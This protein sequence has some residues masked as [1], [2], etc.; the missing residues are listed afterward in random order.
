MKTLDL[1]ADIYNILGFR[2]GLDA[3]AHAT[4]GSNKSADGLMAIQWF[5]EGKLEQLI[6]YCC[7]DVS[8]TKKLYESG[9]DNGFVMYNDRSGRKKKIDVAWR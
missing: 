2:I 8:I 7:D 6:A 4:L 5:K 3:L 1:L 9:R